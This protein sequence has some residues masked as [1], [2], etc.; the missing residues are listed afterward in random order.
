MLAGE[1]FELGTEG[2][3]FAPLVD[4]L[5]RL[6]GTTTP[7]ELDT[8]LGPAR[9]ELAWLLPELGDDDAP[10]GSTSQAQLLERLLA[11]L[12]RLAQT[13][14][15]LLVVEDL[16]WADRSTLEL[17]AF[18][19]RAF[20]DAPVLL[21]MTYRFDELHRHHPLRP[22][23]TSWDRARSVRRIELRRLDRDE[24]AAQ[25]GAIVGD[26]VPDKLVDA[27]F[28][29]SAGNA[30]FAEEVLG[31]I[32]QG[33]ATG[34]LPPSLRDVLL[35]H[36]EALSEPSQR[37]V[38]AASAAGT[39]VP[40]ALLAA[41]V[42]MPG[43]E[44][45]AALR[46]IVER[47]LM[48][49]DDVTFG[50]SFRH[51][52]TRDAVYHDMLP[53]EKV[54]LHSAYGEALTRSPDLAGRT[55]SAMLAHHWYAALDLP[56]ALVAA[57]DAGRQADT[58]APADALQHFE[59]ALEVWP[60]ISDVHQIAGVD[61]VEVLQAA[62]SAA[63]HAGLIDRCLRLLD[64]ALAEQPAGV[65]DARRVR[66]LVSRARALRD[67]GRESEG[68][69]VLTDALAL[70][71]EHPPSE[72][73]AIILA[74][75]ANSMLRLGQMQRS[76]EL[77]QATVEA[78]RSAGAREQEADGLISI[79][80]AWHTL[81]NLSGGEARIQEGL[82]RA[83]EIGAVTIAL[84]GYINLADTLE[85]ACRHQE[86]SETARQ[87]LEFLR[88]SG[89]TRVEE[90]YLAGNM[91]EPLVRLGR[92][93]EAYRIAT[94]ALHGDREGLFA[95]TLLELVAQVAVYR[96][97]Y[98]EAT[99]RLAEAKVLLGADSD[100]QFTL[101]LAFIEA[102]VA[103][104]S[105]RPGEALHIIDKVLDDATIW[106]RYRWP[107]V[108][109]AMRSTNEELV[110]AQDSRQAAPATTLTSMDRWSVVADALAADTDHGRAYRALTAGERSGPAAGAGDASRW[111]AAVQAC[112]DA[113]DPYL[114]AYAL[115]QLAEALVAA[116]DRV[117]ASRAAR[118]SA[119]T[120]ER[121]GAVP[122]AV[123]AGN[124][125]RR[126][127]LTLDETPQTP[128]AANDTALDRLGLT[129]RE[130]EV[131]ALL[132]AGQQNGQIAKTLF[133]SPKTVSVHVSNILAKLNVHGRVEA[134][135]VAHRLG[136]FGPAEQ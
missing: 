85:G 15:L 66:I 75:M 9:R 28:E 120:S 3:P 58:R 1:C 39:W 42:A 129:E 110:R 52:L 77:A 46:E 26:S 105:G 45:S 80:A 135:A 6:V 59:R 101:P 128:V 27:V 74:A 34:D 111:S 113:Q 68:F 55:A 86:A 64:Q 24:V 8:F 134:A 31:I 16:H 25:L 72:N 136:V 30:Y 11:M 32:Q 23:L 102:E 103:R 67:L 119:R 116:G 53:G 5:R 109:L 114:V 117:E 33:R 43:A 79:G 38:R 57:L 130:R 78:A 124:L 122:L 61:H 65:D 97:D 106:P 87:G 132:A 22:L 92:W 37:V 2:L 14:P 48:V 96:G 133:I 10:A 90:A 29:R 36:I 62:A 95:S 63:W 108:W 44:F 54:L 125:A 94:T 71:P 51:A 19:V 49:V 107:L 20:R 98:E 69:Q 50:Y 4:I 13:R 118:E 121:I 7:A 81:G 35:T 112:R 47:H 84:R 89:G 41:V 91:A 56:R 21:L 76:L 88:Q 70:A 99:R 60:R 123:A 131:L 83:V 127:R 93:E 126:A 115:L 100:L 82:D 18:L 104:G 12:G 40:E 17:V 73:R